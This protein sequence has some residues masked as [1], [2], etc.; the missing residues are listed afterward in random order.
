MCSERGELEILGVNTEDYHTTL[1][2]GTTIGLPSQLL[3]RC[4]GLASLLAILTVQVS[5]FSNHES[6]D[7]ILCL[8]LIIAFQTKPTFSCSLHAV[9]D[10][11]PLI[12]CACIS[13]F[14]LYS[15]LMILACCYSN[16]LHSLASWPLLIL[17]RL[18]GTFFLTSFPLSFG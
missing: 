10:L 9:L 4:P 2:R 14:S 3:V 17:F 8:R 12:Y 16:M 15:V 6:D 18:P 11:V 5:D 13:F 7:V 1:A